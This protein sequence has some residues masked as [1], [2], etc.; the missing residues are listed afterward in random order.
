[1]TTVQI[2]RTPR[3]FSIRV[4]TLTTIGGC[5]DLWETNHLR[6]NFATKSDTQQYID[7]NG[8]AAN[9]VGILIIDKRTAQ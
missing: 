4:M 5:A 3:Y 7:D 1:M 2:F 6:K 8:G 9:E